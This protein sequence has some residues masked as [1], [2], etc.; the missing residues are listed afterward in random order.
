MI[1]RI[2]LSLIFLILSMHSQAQNYIFNRL[3]IGDGLLSNHVLCVWQDKIGYLW[4]GTQSGLQRF[5]GFSMRTVS[6]Q[7]VDQIL[8]DD[9]GRV[10][11]RSGSKIGIM[12]SGNFSIRY[13]SYDGDQE[14][15][16][17]FKIWLRKDRNNRVFLVHINNNCQY[18]NENTGRFSKN[19]TPFNLPDSL[20]IAD[21]V[22]DPILERYWIVSRNDF[23]YWDSD[24]GSYQSQSGPT[25][26]QLLNNLPDRSV[27]SRLYIDQKNR[28]WMASDDSSRNRFFCFDRKTGK[29]TADT[30]GLKSNDLFEVYGFGTYED[31]ITIAYGLNYFRGHHGEFYVDLKTPLNNPYGVHFNAINGIFE[32]KEKILWVATDNGLYYTNGNKNHYTHIIISQEKQRASISSFM[33]DNQ[34][35][36]WVGTWGKGLYL[37]EEESKK[38]SFTTISA[39]NDLGVPSQ[40][41]LTIC[42][43]KNGIIWAGGDRSN[44]I[45]YNPKRN[46]A[47]SYSPNVFKNSMIRQI[48][49]DADGILW[50]GLQNGEVWKYNPSLPFTESSLQRL[51]SLGGA[52]SRMVF[53]SEKNLWITVTGVGIIIIDPYNNRIINTIGISHAGSSHIAGLRDILPINDTLVYLTGE[54]FGTINPKT[55]KVNFEQ[56]YTGRLSGT[57]YTLQQDKN[58]NIWLGGAS[59]IYKFNPVTKVL[60]R[61]AQQDGLITIHN[62]SYVPER[63]TILPNGRLAFGGNQHLV[64]FNP[65]EYDVALPPPNVTITGFQLNNQ[66]LSIDSLLQ[67]EIISLPYLHNS[68]RVDFAA[69]SF[70]QRGRLTYEYK[71]DGL[72]DTW[73]PLTEKG[74]VN[75]NFL[76]HGRYQFLVRVKNEENI[77]S[78][79]TTRLELKISA[80]FWKTTWFYLLVILVAGSIL[81]YLHRLRLQKLLHIEQVR[82]RLARDLH[83]D[84]GST[85]STINILSSIAL[86]QNSLDEAKS[87][88]YLGTI[89]QSTRQMM[90]AMDDIV[91]SINPVNDSIARIV[92]R[93][94]ETAGT[95]LEPKNIEY[96][97]DT[98]PAIMDLPLSMEARREI[99]LIFKEALN[100]IVKYASCSMVVIK[101]EK[102]GADL[103]LTLTDNGIGFK[104]PVANNT[105]RGNGLKNM[106]IRADSIN[107]KLS[108]VSEPGKGT[109]INLLMP[110]T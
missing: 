40:R 30:L 16:G 23:G 56:I 29:F 73:T 75:Y 77:Y 86:E 100:N 104:M 33:A 42:E 85:L 50:I 67:Q 95:V 18:F 26:D 21:V 7:R 11:V 59:G 90:E 79:I 37:L 82:N 44:L 10:W 92:A 87:K 66:Y 106:N 69:I 27:I 91:W 89:S 71:L 94:K 15:Y 80:P 24:S 109:S 84:M 54:Q 19:H 98:E 43:D 108:V 102:K 3:S 14:V 4:I 49:C 36:L 70:N 103:S 47:T 13:V 2:T 34:N 97:F 110:I 57:V 28:F 5:D 20:K 93:M 9:E 38:S 78:P 74:H 60:T 55:F 81:Y 1:P 52:V 63:S 45:K 41:I 105:V 58:K 72:D 22:P 83:D 51:F 53:V 25:T 107:G 76:P 6:E 68:F 12:N 99:F 46:I 62:N 39:M 48:L 101:L 32:D 17:L 8:S 96:S 88:Q 31:S 65:E 64:I 35:R 61:Y